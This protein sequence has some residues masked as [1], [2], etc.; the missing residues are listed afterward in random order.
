MG[1][2]PV[3]CC[4]TLSVQFNP[5]YVIS[6]HQYRHDG[7][8]LVL[9]CECILYFTEKFR[10]ITSASIQQSARSRFLGLL[11]KCSSFYLPSCFPFCYRES[12][13]FVSPCDKGS[14]NLASASSCPLDNADVSKFTLIFSK[15]ILFIFR[16]FYYI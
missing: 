14:I 9:V 13:R 15:K 4:F 5:F 6:N 11:F 16:S 3:S 12:S 2:A 10:E 7:S 1:F 8:N